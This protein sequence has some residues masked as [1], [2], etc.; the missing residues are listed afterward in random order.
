MIFSC[1]WRVLISNSGY[2]AHLKCVFVFFCFFL[3]EVNE[4]EVLGVFGDGDGDGDG[5]GEGE[6]RYP[7]CIS[8]SCAL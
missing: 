2:N 3:E 4:E 7:G 8:N 5:D 1:S 6:V